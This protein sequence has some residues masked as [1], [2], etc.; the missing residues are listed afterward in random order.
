[1]FKHFILTSALALLTLSAAATTP[2]RIPLQVKQSDG[3][4]LTVFRAGNA[5]C[6]YYITTDGVPVLQDRNSND[7]VYAINTDGRLTAGTVLAHE[8]DFRNDMEAEHVSTAK[9]ALLPNSTPTNIL[10][11]NG[12]STSDGLGE[13]MLNS[14]GPVNSIGE[15]TIPVLMV[16]F[17]DVKFLPT[18]T[19]DKLSRVFNEKG[20]NDE[21]NC[22][23]SVH[24]YFISQSNGIFSPNFEVV[25]VVTMPHSM[26]YYGRNDSY[27]NDGRVFEL[28]QEAIKLA[29]DNGVD[30]SKYYEEFSTGGNGVPLISIYHAG[31]GEHDSWKPISETNDMIWAHFLQ[32]EFTVGDKT[33]GSYFIG[34]ERYKENTWTDYRLDG[35][36]VFVHEFSHALGLPDFYCTSN[37]TFDNETPAY[38]SIMDYGQYVG[39]GYAPVGYS[40]Y[41]RSF[42]G[43][44]KIEELT[45]QPGFH[46]LYQFG[47]EDKGSTAYLIRNPSNPNEYYI[48]ENR[49]V[50]TWYA[51]QFGTGMLV[52]H[53]DY[54]SNSWVRNT[55]N[56][57]K[58]H[59]RYQNVPA[60]D[61]WQGPEDYYWDNW[62][63]DLFPGKKKVTQFTDDMELYAALPFA[64]PG[65]GRPIYNITEQDGVITFSYIDKEASG[66]THLDKSQP[67]GQAIYSIDGRLIDGHLAK[68]GVYIKGGKKIIR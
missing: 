28:V 6:H 40:A 22:V 57:S 52:F 15:H 48:L 47:E 55:L 17:E 65:F 58:G 3:T 41:E 68:S 20:Y 4:T 12:A 25:G 51:K 35:I 59:L 38:W 21:E 16:Q 2:K 32:Y 45:D 36:G 54:N 24:D 10:A 26:A 29:Q 44:L 18:T 63:A 30:F 61:K 11:A 19:P 39:N 33:F 27:G 7:L 37:A 56:N 64:G 67:L 9:K 49:Q 42:M 53:V 34:N 14:V 23:G 62:K 5:Q 13:Y 31:E 50:G 43:W 66:I 8:I 60:D 46:T 1:M